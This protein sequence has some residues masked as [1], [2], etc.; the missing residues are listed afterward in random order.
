MDLARIKIPVA[1]LSQSGPAVVTGDGVVA[2][3]LRSTCGAIVLILTIIAV[4]TTVIVF[5]VTVEPTTTVVAHGDCVV[6]TRLR[7]ILR[8]RG[9]GRDLT[10]ARLC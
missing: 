8:V 9:I 7:L 10:D 2:S 3:G 5:A 6:I 4:R 1:V